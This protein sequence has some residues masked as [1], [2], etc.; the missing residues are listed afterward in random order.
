MNLKST[1]RGALIGKVTAGG[2]AEKAGLRGSE[3]QTTINGENVNVGGDVIIAIDNQ[4]V[5][6]FDDIVAYLARSTR[7]GSDGHGDHSA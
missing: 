4:P 2:P 1:Q 6:D 5:K 3:K 7:C